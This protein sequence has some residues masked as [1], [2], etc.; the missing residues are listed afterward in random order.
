MRVTSRCRR[1]RRWRRRAGL[2][3][4]EV[5]A[6]RDPRRHRDAALSASSSGTPSACTLRTAS[7]IV[8]TLPASF[9]PAP[10]RRPE[11]TTPR[12]ASANS[13]S[14]IAA[15]AT[16]SVTS[17]S[18][19]RADRHATTSVS[20]P[21][22]PVGVSCTVTSSRASAASAMPGSRGAAAHRVEEMREV[23]RRGRTRRAPRRRLLRVAGRDHDAALEQDIDQLHAPGSSGASVTWLTLPASSSRPAAPGR[24]SAAIPP[25]HA[26]P[27]RRHERPFD[28][29]ADH[30]RPAARRP[31]GI[32]R[33]AATRSASGAVM[34][35]GW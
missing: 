11:L 20:P 2:Q 28:V 14:P 30:M 9:P 25:V 17:A 26:E 21:V 35:V 22:V 29:R 1:A 8:S 3:A 7:I 23:A 34:N 33:R 27:L 12:P 5:G 4:A 19:P 24:A 32:A 13:P 10:A 18:R 31:A 15:A 6:A 16:A